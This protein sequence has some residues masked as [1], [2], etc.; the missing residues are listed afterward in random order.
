MLPAFLPLCM[1]SCWMSDTRSWARWKG[2][3]ETIPAPDAFSESCQPC[4]PAEFVAQNIRV[5]VFAEHEIE[6]G[7][8]GGRVVVE[9]IGER[10][11]AGLLAAEWA[12]FGGGV[13]YGELVVVAPADL[14]LHLPEGGQVVDAVLLLQRYYGLV[15]TPDATFPDLIQ[16]LLLALVLRAFP[17][18]LEVV[19]QLALG[20]SDVHV[21]LGDHPLLE[22]VGEGTTKL[23]R[24]L[25]GT[26]EDQA[27]HPLLEA[28]VAGPLPQV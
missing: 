19:E 21:L 2:N 6:S 14:G 17:D 4:Y 13:A 24:P 28:D 15:G 5:L 9:D 22:L 10:P 7:A 25:F 23:G 8:A 12:L 20:L 11:Y 27:S 18:G 3:H 1:S 26:G 16:Q